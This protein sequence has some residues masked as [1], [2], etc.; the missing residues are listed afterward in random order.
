M[1]VSDSGNGALAMVVGIVTKCCGGEER[2][3]SEREWGRNGEE[4]ECP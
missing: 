3:R 2:E 1:A 4:K